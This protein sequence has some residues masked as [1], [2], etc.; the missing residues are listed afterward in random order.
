[1]WPFSLRIEYVFRVFESS[2]LKKTFMP[3][4]AEASG[5]LEY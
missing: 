2:F 3:K 5:N 4:K 1:M